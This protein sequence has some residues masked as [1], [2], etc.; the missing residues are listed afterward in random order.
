MGALLIDLVVIVQRV[1]KLALIIV[2]GDT[3]IY[4]KVLQ[5]LSYKSV[6]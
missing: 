2:T 5:S 1:C 6:P 4:F 3:I